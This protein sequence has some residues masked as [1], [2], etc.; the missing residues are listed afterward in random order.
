M[1]KR[2]ADLAL[3]AFDATQDVKARDVIGIDLS[4]LESYTDFILIAS[5]GSDRQVLAIAD[6]VIKKLFKKHHLHPLGVEGGE[7]AEWV[8]IDFGEVVVHVF[9]DTVRENYHLEDMWLNV[10]PIAQDDFAKTVKSLVSKKPARK[11]I[12]ATRRKRTK[13]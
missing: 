3:S 13:S 1:D 11:K 12:G 8:L 4:D 5:G 2:T 10:K 6:S 9:L 7:A